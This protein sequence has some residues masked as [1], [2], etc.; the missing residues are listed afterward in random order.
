MCVSVLS[1]SLV[2]NFFVTPTDYSPPGFS[3]HGILQTRTLGWV[4]ISS[5]K[6]SSWPRDLIHVS[7]NS[8]INRQVL[9]HWATWEAPKVNAL[10]YNSSNVLLK[11]WCLHI[12]ASN[13]CSGFLSFFFF[14]LTL[15]YCIGFDSFLIILIIV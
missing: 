15:Q 3:V 13:S 7:C 2:S 1:H 11:S 6:G 10:F 4:A 9:Y 8:C 5:F 12:L 14:F